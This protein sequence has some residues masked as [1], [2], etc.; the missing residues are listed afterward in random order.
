MIKTLMNA[1]IIL[2]LTATAAS[3]AN[4]PWTGAAPRGTTSAHQQMAAQA[5]KVHGQVGLNGFGLNPNSIKWGKDGGR[6]FSFPVSNVQASTLKSA[7]T[8]RYQVYQD[9]GQTKF[10]VRY[11]HPN[12]DVYM[13]LARGRNK[14]KEYRDHYMVTRTEVGLSAVLLWGLTKPTPT[15]KNSY[16]WPMVVDSNTGELA[17]WA[18]TNGKWKPHLGW[19]QSEYAPAFAEHCPKLPRVNA[20]SS[21]T[22]DTVQDLAR[23]ARPVRIQ[24]AFANSSRNPLTAGMYYHFNPPVR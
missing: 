18:T 5:A 4:A 17:V 1:V 8:G 3:A 20:V 7:I 21:Q 24:P 19:V 2:A 12:G 11:Y 16:A 6:N 15:G 9:P 14:H 10:S 22:G 23:G 13:C